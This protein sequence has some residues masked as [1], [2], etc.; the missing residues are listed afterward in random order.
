MAAD[1]SYALRVAVLA[2]LKATSAVTDLVP[3]ARIVS[4]ARANTITKPFIE[5]VGVATSKGFDTK[6]TDGFEGIFEVHVYSKMLANSDSAAGASV[7]AIAAAVIDALTAGTINDAAHPVTVFTYETGAKFE[8]PDGE[9]Y[10]SVSRFRFI[11]C[12]A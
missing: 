8:E 5:V 12:K 9:T 10:H 6:T 4:V 7:E 1:S 3:A 11:T 2:H